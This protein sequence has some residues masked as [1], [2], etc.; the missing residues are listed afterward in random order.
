MLGIGMVLGHFAFSQSDL[1]FG[2][3]AFAC[4]LSSLSFIVVGMK[5]L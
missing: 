5:G 4:G 1:G 3:G 2:A